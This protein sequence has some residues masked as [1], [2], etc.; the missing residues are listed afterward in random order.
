MIGE[1]LKTQ[2]G[3]ALLSIIWGLG[4]ATLFKVAIPPIKYVS[5]SKEIS[6]NLW[7]Y[8]QQCYKVNPYPSKCRN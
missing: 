2:T 5:P 6:E 7:K 4:L 1:F 3:I 8:D